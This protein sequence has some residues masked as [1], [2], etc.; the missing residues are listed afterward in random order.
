MANADEQEVISGKTGLKFMYGDLI[1]Q[2]LLFLVKEA[3]HTVER[4][5]EE[6][7]VDG[8]LGHID[9]V[10][11]GVT[12]DVKSA[13]P[14]SY[15]KF[16]RGSLFEDDPFGYIGQISGYASVVTPDRGGAFL[17]FDKVAGD[18]CVLNVG[19][20]ITNGFNVPKRI[21]HLKEVIASDVKPDRC[22]EDESDGKSGN[23]KLGTQCSYCAFKK[24][25]W[26]DANDGVGLRTFLYSGRPRFLTE[27]RRTPDVHEVPS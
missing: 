20:S 14:L 23:R 21:T 24:P 6:I 17:A 4:E 3:G 5:Q 19:P 18:I 9:A 22:Y 25:C 13:S 12:V 8:V 15:A 1:E 10:I 27:V 16:E 7:E 11:D 26:S 2:M